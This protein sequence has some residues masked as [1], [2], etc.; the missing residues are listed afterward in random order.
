MTPEAFVDKLISTIKTTT[1]GTVDLTSQRAALLSTYGTGGRA[2]TMRQAVE[3]KAFSDAE[4]NNAFVEMQ[5]FGYLRRDPETD[6]YNFWIDVLNNR[7]PNNYRSM[8]KAFITAQEYR[9]RF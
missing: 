7:V 9:D 8:V 5:Y 4:F 6:G 1:K 2:A 3:T